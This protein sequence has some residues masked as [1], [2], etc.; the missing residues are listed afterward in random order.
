MFPPEEKCSPTARNTITRTRASLVECLEHQPKL[1]ACG[2]SMMLTAA[3]RGSHLRVAS[4][5]DS[6]RKPSSVA[7]RGSAKVIGWSC[8]S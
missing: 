5:I 3:D 8:V 4:G 7:K 2:I 1:V 6:M